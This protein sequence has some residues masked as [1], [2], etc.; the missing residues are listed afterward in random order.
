MPGAPSLL[1][2]L[3]RSADQFSDRCAIQDGAERVTYAELVRAAEAVAAQLRELG[4]ERGDRVALVMPNCI[5]FVAAFYGTLW[6]GGTVVMLNAA[7]KERD[8][9]SWLTDSQARFVCCVG[10]N[11]EVDAAIARLQQAPTIVSVTDINVPETGITVPFRRPDGDAAA[12]VLYTSGTTGRP[13]GVALSHRNL[14]SNMSAIVDY[15]ELTSRDSVV[16][17][18][19]FYY[20]YGSSVLHTHLQVGARIVLEQNMVYPHMVVETLARERASGFAGVPSTYALLL[21]RVKLE[22]YDLGGL[23]YVTQAGGAMPPAMTRRLCE[24]LPGTRVFVMYG[25]TEATARLTYLPPDRLEE[26]MG[27]VGVPVRGVTLQIR[28][29]DGSPA[30]VDEVGEIWAQ[31]PNVMLGYW[32]NEEATREV[33]RDGWLRTGD[34]GRR[35]ADGFLY[36]V[37]RRA[38]IIKVG[39]H[40]VHPQ[41]IEEVIAEMPE[42]QEVAVVGVEDDVLGQTIHAYVVPAAQRHLTALPVQAHCRARLAGYKVPKVVS[43]VEALP[44]TASGKVRRA[45]LIE[46]IKQ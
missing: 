35:D 40:R 33:L 5:Q 17:V 32:R 23:R 6:V 42:V 10:V 20:S 26:K 36:I 22:N 29:A 31:G 28:R 41:D 11:P 25:Q 3:L 15:L 18:L 27:S 45:E 43:I 44:R 12:C 46:G 38:D 13:K 4:L 7:A 34:M 37:G 30:D 19:P 39:A 14:V 9:T 2:N 8:F 21:S 1:D 24:A 16:S